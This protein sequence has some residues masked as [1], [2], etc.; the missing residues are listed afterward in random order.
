MKTA[1]LTNELNFG[2]LR[3]SISVLF[4]TETTKEIRI[5]MKKGQEMKEHQ[6]PYPITVELFEG[7][8]NFGVQGKKHLIGKG[9]LLAL[10]GG[11]PHDL[12]AIE[13]SII[14]LTLSKLDKVER[15]ENVAK[16]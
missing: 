2:E 3:P 7:A 6:T 15:V 1:K 5:L 10:D 9:D 11:V 8:V 14:R 16:Q 4:E 13:D 12:V